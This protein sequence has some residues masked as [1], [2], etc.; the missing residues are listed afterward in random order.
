M[1]ISKKKWRVQY[2]GDIE[3]FDNRAREYWMSK[4]SSEKFRETRSLID[5]AMKLKG[6]SYKDVSRLL[7]STAV[8]KRK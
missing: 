5:T 3:N 2:K 6:I 1:P 4:S 7:R 8:L